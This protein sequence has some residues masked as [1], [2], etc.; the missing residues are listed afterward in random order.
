[1]TRLPALDPT[2]ATGEAKTLLDAVQKKLGIAPNILRTMANA[3]AVLKAYLGFGEALAGGRFDAKSREA[4]ALTVAGANT[5]EYCASA[6]TAFSRSL[7]VDDAEIGL[8]LRGHASD[9]KL[10]AA[11]VFARRIVETRGRVS[12]DDL[13]AVRGAGHDDGAIAEIVANV[14][15]NIFPN[16]FTPVAQPAPA[17]PKVEPTRARAA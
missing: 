5:C 3:P 14:A 15:A 16:Y 2:A 12:D 17:F 1:M 11:L 10:D 8:R 4:I 6:H 9:T 13:A 7:K